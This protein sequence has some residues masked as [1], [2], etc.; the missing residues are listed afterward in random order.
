MIGPQFFKAAQKPRYESSI[1]GMLWSFMFNLVLCLLL[2][3]L[4]VRE[5]KKRGRMLEGK[6][7]EEVAVMKAES[8]LQGFENVTDRQNVCCNSLHI[9]IFS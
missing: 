7:V 9:V 2:R 3:F 4:Y 1:Q 5:N 6:S 8:N